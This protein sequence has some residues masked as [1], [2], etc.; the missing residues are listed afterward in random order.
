MTSPLLKYANATLLIKETGPATIT[1]GRITEEATSNHLIRCWLRRQQT[2]GTTSGADY[3]GNNMPGASG[4]TYLY[5]GYALQHITVSSNYDI[6]SNDPVSG[7]LDITEP[8][9]WLIAGNNGQHK[10]GSEP[11]K[12]CT[13][14]RCS[15]RYGNTGIDKIIRDNIKG[16]EIMIQSGDILR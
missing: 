12:Y 8:L 15:G 11:I 2:T 4:I 6:E 7:W 9:T 3:A 1:A 14:E 10:Q 16:L 5:N 13:I